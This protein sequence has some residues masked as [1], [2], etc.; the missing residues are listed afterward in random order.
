MDASLS[1][2]LLDSDPALRWQVERDLLGADELVWQTTRA[3][4][5]SE[6][7]GAALLAKQDPD[8]RWAGGAYFPGDFDFEGP[9]AQPGAGQP[10]TATTWSLNFLRDWGTPASA[11][12]D[13]ANRLAVGCRWEYEDLPYWGGETD[14]CINAFTL[15]NGQWLGADVAGIGQWFVDHEMAEGGWNCE[16]VEGSTRASIHSTLNSLKGIYEYQLAGQGSPELDAARVRAEE[17]LLQREL[18][19]KLTDGEPLVSGITDFRYPLVWRYSTLNVMDY[20]RKSY[21]LRGQAP[22]ARMAKAVQTIRDLQQPDGR[23]V[24]AGRIPGRMWFEV[25]VPAGEPSK[26]VTFL[27]LRVLSWWD[28]QTG[29][30]R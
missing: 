2:W 27:A 4:V 23:W 9:E 7:F 17:Y 10:W 18:L 1:D 16:W 19:H 13:T 26:W 22:D 24:Q 12:G 14:C 21:L 3:R 29:S 25:D 15:A 30:E 20:F 8:G 11:L 5:A 28:E 6:G